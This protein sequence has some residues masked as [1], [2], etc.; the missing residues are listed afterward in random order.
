M[1]DSIASAI[2]A[3]RFGLGARPGELA[4]IGGDARAWLHAQLRGPPPVLAGADLRP[5]AQIL[6]Q[7]LDLRREIQAQRKARA[8]EGSAASGAEDPAQQRLPQFLRPI[9]AS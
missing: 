9:Y 3:N 7:P 5:S 4:L 2:A 8:A 1:G 6:P